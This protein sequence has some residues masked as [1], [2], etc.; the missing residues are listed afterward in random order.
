MPLR[1]GNDDIKIQFSAYQID[2]GL[3]VF[4]IPEYSCTTFQILDN[5]VHSLKYG[6]DVLVFEVVENFL[7]M[8]PYEPRELLHRF[9]PAVHHPTT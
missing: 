8:S 5:A 9:Q 2:H 4:H 7:A 6:V 3:E 1:L